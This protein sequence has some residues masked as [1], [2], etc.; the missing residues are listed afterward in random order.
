MIV[1]IVYFHMVGDHLL[2]SPAR[3]TGGEI[4]LAVLIFVEGFF[5]FV[6]LEIF[7]GLDIELFDVFFETR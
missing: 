4:S 1:E 5:D 6:P 2:T 7:Q 3:R